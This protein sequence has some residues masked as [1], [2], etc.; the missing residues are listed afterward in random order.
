[1]TTTEHYL[2][3]SCT[4]CLMLI[5]NGDTSGNPRCETEE[6]EAEYLAAVEANTSGMHLCPTSW[7][8]P[9][10][11]AW[12]DYDEDEVTELFALAFS[13]ELEVSAFSFDLDGV[14]ATGWTET[15]RY[16][17][18]DV[19]AEFTHT[20]C[21]VCGSHLGGDKHPVAAWKV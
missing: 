3:R 8:P 16:Y 14:T 15:D 19:E 5:A 11:N 20:G 21:D 18:T 7:E 6:G 12:F 13:G 10:R 17:G 2:Y 1:M 4:D 9:V